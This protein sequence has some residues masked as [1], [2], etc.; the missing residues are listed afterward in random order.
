MGAELE[1]QSNRRR[2]KQA[3][4]KGD[5]REAAILDAAENLLDREGVE[6]VTVEAIANGAGISRGALYF[7]FGSKEE[8]VTA[9]VA[10]TVEVIREVTRLAADE[11]HDDPVKTIERTVNRVERLWKEHG[12]VMRAAVDYTPFIPDVS[13]LWKGT[14]EASIDSL[15]KVLLR[16]GVPNIRGPRGARALTTALCWA[17]ERNFYIAAAGD[18]SL[19]DA[20]R[21]SLELW[22]RTIQ[23]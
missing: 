22:I 9:L 21:R 10:R 14:L 15:T 20:G 6:P 7:Y 4:R 12:V 23:A 2:R 5:V 13:D 18:G 3:P 1:K 8:I 11:V 19:R 17:T 16:A